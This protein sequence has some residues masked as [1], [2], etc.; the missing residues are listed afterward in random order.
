[1]DTRVRRIAEVMAGTPYR[2]LSCNRPYDFGHVVPGFSFNGK[3]VTEQAAVAMLNNQAPILYA[4]DVLATMNLDEW[5]TD[6]GIKNSILKALEA[7]RVI[8]PFDQMFI[9]T[10]FEMRRSDGDISRMNYASFVQMDPFAK[11]APKTCEIVKRNLCI[12][13]ARSY[14]GMQMQNSGATDEQ[15]L[16]RNQQEET[17]QEFQDLVE[18]FYS[19][20]QVGIYSYIL[21]KKKQQPYGP[22][23]LSI[24]LLDE[25]YKL[26]R[27]TEGNP[28]QVMLCDFDVHDLLDAPEAS[29]YP[30]FSRS[31][32]KKLGV[33]I[34]IAIALQSLSLL[35]CSNI[36]MVESGT[37]NSDLSKKAR[38]VD[39]L[40][41]VRHHE[42]RVKVGEQLLRIDGRTEG[43]QQLN[44][45][46]AVRGHFRDYSTGKGLFGKYKYNCVWVPQFVRGSAE[47][48]IVTRDYVLE[49][50]K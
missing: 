14:I 49:N 12:M 36:R 27:V 15:M 21:T 50:A 17:D 25:N 43:G 35:N 4:D 45:L 31:N 11:I 37:T 5:S 41:S 2:V 28:H 22:W 20:K 30:D 9:D 33:D 38:A 24:Y 26:V 7:P 32:G 42:L 34:N 8:P 46:H 18:R 6:A 19:L 10:S 3:M 39:R 47:D 29:F 40:A 13:Y 44:P 16:A 48:G 1:M 23:A